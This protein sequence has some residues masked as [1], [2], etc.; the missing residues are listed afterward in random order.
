M[1]ETAPT[2]TRNAAVSDPGPTIRQY[3]DWLQ[4]HPDGL[5]T[6]REIHARIPEA[7]PLSDEGK[8]LA[9]IVREL[10][11]IREFMEKRDVRERMWK[12]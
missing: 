11:A 1:T 10:T 5:P 4:Q 12:A 7:K 2:T 6:L 8:L 9:R 3:T